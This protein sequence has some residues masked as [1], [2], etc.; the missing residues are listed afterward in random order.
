MAS[1]CLHAHGQWILPVTG[2]GHPVCPVALD[3]GSPHYVLHRHIHIHVHTQTHAAWSHLIPRP[4]S[5][6]DSWP[7]PSSPSGS[8]LLRLPHQPVVS[9]VQS[10]ILSLHP[11]MC[12]KPP[13]Q[14]PAQSGLY[15]PL[16]LTQ[17]DG[18]HTW[19]MELVTLLGAPWEQLAQSVHFCLG[20]WDFSTCRCVS[21]SASGCTDS[22]S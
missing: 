3:I 5:L 16:T 4:H 1:L 13:I 19:T 15:W 2:L 6:S 17:R 14:W 8:Q 22:Y 12:S 11:I 18:F 20:Y 7:W 9:L 10:E 21:I